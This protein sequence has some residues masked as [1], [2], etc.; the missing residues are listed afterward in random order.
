MTARDE[1]FRW[2]H[3]LSYAKGHRHGWYAAL[4]TAIQQYDL[5][6]KGPPGGARAMLVRMLAERD[7]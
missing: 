1:R 2:W 7:R 3:H 4:E 5:E 6:H